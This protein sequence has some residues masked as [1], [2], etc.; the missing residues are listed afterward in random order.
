M[1][2][3]IDVNNLSYL[4]YLLDF[5]L[6][7]WHTAYMCHFV[8]KKRGKQMFNLCHK[9]NIYQPLLVTCELRKANDS[10]VGA[11]FHQLGKGHHRVL[12]S[13][14]SLVA[15]RAAVTTHLVINAL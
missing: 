13:G 12:T 5:W 2:D 11:M 14:N 15:E 4:S 6:Y 8:L 3:F 1:L 10:N 9:N 7:P